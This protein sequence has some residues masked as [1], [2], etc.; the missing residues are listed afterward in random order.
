SSVL[1]NGGDRGDGVADEANLVGAERVLVL[2]DGEDAVRDGQVFA[3]DDGMDAGE[4]RRLRGVNGFDERV[5]EVRA[6]DFAV[7]HAR[8]AYVVGELRLTDALRARVNL[9]EGLTDDLQV[10]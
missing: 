9:A 10:L 3:G 1:V 7:E 4:G 6:E 8:Q 2:A 5:W